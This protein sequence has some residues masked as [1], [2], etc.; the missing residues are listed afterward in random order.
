MLEIRYAE[1]SLLIVRPLFK[2]TL[3]LHIASRLTYFKCSNKFPS[4]YRRCSREGERETLLS[5]SFPSGSS[6]S[7]KSNRCLTNCHT[8]FRRRRPRRRSIYVAADAPLLPP[9]IHRMRIIILLSRGH[10]Y[11]VAEMF[12]PIFHTG[13]CARGGRWCT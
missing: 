2:L 5:F 6:V 11:E 12:F 9:L 10:L 1:R 7:Y 13:G 4:Y 3:K 8:R